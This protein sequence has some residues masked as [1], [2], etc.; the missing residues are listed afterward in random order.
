MRSGILLL[1][2]AGTLAVAGCA[3]TST[4]GVNSESYHYQM[5]VSYLEER[6]YTSA[7]K[8]LSEA[9]KQDDSNPELQYNLGR[10]L[11]G[12]R[13]LD[14]AEG[15]FL[16][17]LALRPKYS[18]ARNDLGV[19]YLETGRWDNAIQQFK[20]VKD[21][22]FY[23]RPDFAQ[24]NLGLAYLGKGEYGAAMAE[25]KAVQA[26]SPRNPVALVSIGRVL[27]A[28]GK[29]D[30]AIEE[31]RRALSIA[32]DYANGHY[33]L[34]MALMKQSQLAAARQA[35]KEVVRIA[36]DTELGHAAMRYIDL[37]R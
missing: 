7:L 5:G 14:L 9:E 21:D 26:Y 35:F 16:K 15:K 24:L 22:L 37:L 11:V 12:R 13:R 25:F 8:E 29:T 3:T 28:E 2:L 31:Y 18:E 4:N 17:A 1:M 27:F 6:N 36:P 30:L 19:L 33:H 32:P 34:G 20:A 23:P 10:A